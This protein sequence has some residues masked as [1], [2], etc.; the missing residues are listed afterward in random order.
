MNLRRI[1]AVDSITCGVVG[2][3]GAGGAAALDGEL[4]IPTGWLVALGLVLVGSAAVLARL[5]TLEVV[6][7]PAAWLVI[8]VNVVWA[9]ASMV[10]VVA[11]W[12]P[13]TAAGVAVVIAQAAAALALA[14]L[15]WF[16]VRRQSAAASAG[17]G[18]RMAT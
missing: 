14:D 2:A 11:G 18:A 12:W 6:P 10:V 7:P 1:L 5:A 9:A 3:A 13:L 17:P 16:S 8:G 4:G 15:E